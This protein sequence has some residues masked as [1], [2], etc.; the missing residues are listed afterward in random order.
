YTHQTRQE[1]YFLFHMGRTGEHAQGAG[2]FSMAQAFKGN[3]NTH[4]SMK[5]QCH[6]V[7]GLNTPFK[8]HCLFRD[9]K[10][11]QP[12]I[13]CLQET[14]FKTPPT[15]KPSLYPHRYHDTSGQKNRGVSVLISN[16]VSFQHHASHIDSEGRCLV[17]ICTIN[18]SKYTPN[19]TQRNFLHEVLALLSP[20]Q[21]EMLILC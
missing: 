9:L 13:I 5:I 3:H 1:Y 17:V 8:Q 4:H 6:N 11:T 16:K 19:T 18:N 15:L 14:H 12:D 2:A 10:R 20:V 21:E 7:R